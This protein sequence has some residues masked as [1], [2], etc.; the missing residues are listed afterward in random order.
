MGGQGPSADNIFVVVVFFVCIFS[1]QL[2]LK[3]SI[4][5]FQRKLI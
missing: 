5:L 3:K 2:I 4:R 1:P